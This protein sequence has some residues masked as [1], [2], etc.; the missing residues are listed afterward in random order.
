MVISN[1]HALSSA[2]WPRLLVGMAAALALTWPAGVAMASPPE[3]SSAAAEADDADADEATDEAADD[4]ADAD[5][6]VTVAKD[7]GH[8]DADAAEEAAPPKK[9]KHPARAHHAKK[10]HPRKHKRVKQA[11]PP[12]EE[13]EPIDP[14]SWEAFD[15]Y[16][17]RPHFG[18]HF[19]PRFSVHGLGGRDIYAGGGAAISI[20]ADTSGGFYGFFAA[21]DAGQASSERLQYGAV[22]VGVDLG[23]TA[24]AFHLGLR[25]T[26]GYWTAQA[27]VFLDSNAGPDYY[28]SW[29]SLKVGLGAVVAI[30]FYRSRDWAIGLEAEPRVDGLVTGPIYEMGGGGIGLFGLNVALTI[31]Y[32]KPRAALQVVPY[33]G[34]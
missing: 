23:W 24:G 13:A 4:G 27:A 7:K 26:I 11:E 32:Q 20:G 21:F 22:D 33:D 19:G 1:S 9:V 17:A 30:D 8:E 12:E 3:D 34:E 6:D 16:P 18:V 2:V 10:K 31:K 14:Y 28:E 15:P 25:P 29:E 5:S